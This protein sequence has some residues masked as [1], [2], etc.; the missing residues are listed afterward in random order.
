PGPVVQPPPRWNGT[1]RPTRPRRQPFAVPQQAT[2]YDQ[3]RSDDAD[4]KLDRAK[5]LAVQSAAVRKQPDARDG[6][7]AE[8]PFQTNR[9][10]QVASELPWPRKRTLD[11][12]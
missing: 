4:S 3:H 2:E 9:S 5:F 7:H 6:C 8:K 10:G 1:N 12:E 11:G